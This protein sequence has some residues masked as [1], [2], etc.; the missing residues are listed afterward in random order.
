MEEAE[1]LAHRRREAR[2]VLT[3]R[4]QQLEG[5]HQIRLDEGGRAIDGAV[6]VGLRREVEDGV[7]A[8]LADDLLHR[9]AVR[10]VRLHEVKALVG[11]DV[12][13]ALE[14]P[15]VGELVDHHDAGVAARE[16]VADEVRPDESRT[17]RDDPGRHAQRLDVV[18]AGR[19]P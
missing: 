5:P 1:A 4:F 19:H 11:G 15:G 2:E 13:E 3:R 10:D 17:A 18:P 9:G 14:I 7:G 8:L 12:G 16:R 6:D